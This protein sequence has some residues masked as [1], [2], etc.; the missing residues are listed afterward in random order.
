MK[1]IYDY[2]HKINKQKAWNSIFLLFFIW[3]ILAGFSTLFPEKKPTPIFSSEVLSGE[4]SITPTPSQTPFPFVQNVNGDLANILA[5]AEKTMPKANTEGFIIPTKLDQLAFQQIA[6]SIEKDN[7]E[8]ALRSALANNYEILRL[9]DQGDLE[10]ADYIL[11]EQ[12][13]IIK[14]WGTYVFRIKAAQDI[15]IEAPH[16]IADERTPEVAMDI[17]RALNAKALLI[18]GTHRNA[19]QDGSADSAHAPESIFQTMHI[20]L[21]Q[22][23]PQVSKNTIFMQIHGFAARDHPRYPQVVIGH[24][25]KNDPS[26]DILLQNIESAL[27]KNNIKVG[28]CDDTNNYM[29]LCGR[30]NLQASVM[31]EG[32][33]IHI[34]LNESIRK[35]DGRLVDSLILA[36][37]QY[38]Q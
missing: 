35:E 11:K 9:I 26:K 29:D 17:Y 27:K 18:S 10:R 19:N 1:K 23:G 28:I 24:N 20:T 38:H 14:G 34:E 7:P 32:V 16:P 25:W 33:F 8:S 22:L 6:L 3:S 12:L 30:K 2:S 5:E 15:I 13:P 21:F 36:I 37:N 4:S 31:N